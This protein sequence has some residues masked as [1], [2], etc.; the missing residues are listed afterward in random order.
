MG[1]LYRLRNSIISRRQSAEY[2]RQA[3]TSEPEN[4]VYHYSLGLTYQKQGF[5]GNALSEFKKAARLNPKNSEALRKIAA[6][7]ESSASLR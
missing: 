4:D 1:E 5:T 6:I 7:Y 3:V 2:L